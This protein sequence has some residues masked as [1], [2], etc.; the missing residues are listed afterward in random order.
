MRHQSALRRFRTAATGAAILSIAIASIAF[1]IIAVAGATASHSLSISTANKTAS[2]SFKTVRRST[3]TTSYINCAYG[4]N[5]QI[6][7]AAVSGNTSVF[8]NTQ[9]PAETALFTNVVQMVN[10]SSYIRFKW[11]SVAV[12][13]PGGGTLLYDKCTE[14]TVRNSSRHLP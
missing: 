2:G 6:Q 14:I 7:C 13:N 4:T 12:A 10:E 5:S 9:F 3:S 8:C 1:P 11:E